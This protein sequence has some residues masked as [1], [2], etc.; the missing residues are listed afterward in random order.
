MKRRVPGVRRPVALKLSLG[1]DYERRRDVLEAPSLPDPTC[2][3]PRFEDGE[4]LF[5]E[6]RDQ[7]YKG[8]VAK[9]PDGG[10]QRPQVR[11]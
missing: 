3:S 10:A 5:S 1:R 11:P 7:G 9:E 8:I 6:R 4:A 2:V